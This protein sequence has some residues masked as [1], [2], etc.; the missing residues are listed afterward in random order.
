MKK[1]RAGRQLRRRDTVLLAVILFIHVALWRYSDY[2]HAAWLNISPPP[3][4]NIAAFSTL[5]DRAWAYR[6]YALVLQN[7]GS[8]DG[9]NI[10]LRQYDYAHLKDWFFML[11]KMDATSDV[12]PLLAAY[13]FGAVSDPDDPQKLNHIFDYL[14]AVG[15]RPTGEKWRW[16]AHGVY[17]ARHVQKDED[18][19]LALAYLLAANENSDMPVWTRQLPA[20]ILRSRGDDASAYDLMLEILKS[21]V[22]TLHAGEIN[23]MTDYLCNELSV[24]PAQVGNPSFCKEISG[25]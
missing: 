23:F 1:S 19:A 2:S 9:R 18:K 24:D 15:T 4:A 21:N 10:S 3:A 5:S 20:F 6:Y 17:L 22:D 16:L 8:V 12:V 7:K 14:S 25:D 11:D 13:Y